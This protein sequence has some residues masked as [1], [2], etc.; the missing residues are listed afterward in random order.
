M[1]NNQ[2]VMFGEGNKQ[3]Q[4]SDHSL[5]FDPDFSYINLLHEDAKY[6]KRSHL[7]VY[8]KIRRSTKSK[9]K[10]NSKRPK[11]C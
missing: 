4:I 7:K 5:S 2:K 8:S 9:E 6:A 11:D 10:N 3:K 1:Y